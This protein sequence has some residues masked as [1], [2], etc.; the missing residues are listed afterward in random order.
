[1]GKL[2]NFYGKVTYFLY[3]SYVLSMGKL[4]TFY[5][6]VTYFLYE[7]YVI[8]MRKLPTFSKLANLGLLDNALMMYIIA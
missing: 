2:R 3:E 7:S 4:P 6:K 1:M 8:S 5:E